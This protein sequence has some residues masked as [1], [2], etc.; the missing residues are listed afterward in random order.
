MRVKSSVKSSEA[1]V[2][3]DQVWM[4]GQAG[5]DKPWHEVEGVIVMVGPGGVY[6][7]GNL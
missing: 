4:D 1:Q 2:W 5:G 7:G 6:V 3:M